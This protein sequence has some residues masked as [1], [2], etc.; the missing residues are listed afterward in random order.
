MQ[1]T[2]MWDVSYD[3]ELE[4]LNTVVKKQRK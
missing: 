1:K 2:A 3:A 4:F